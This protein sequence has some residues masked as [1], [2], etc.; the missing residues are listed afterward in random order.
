MSDCCHTVA[1]TVTRA[2]G[3]SADRAR[4]EVR[5]VMIDTRPTRPAL[6]PK[7]ATGWRSISLLCWLLAREQ[8][9]HAAILPSVADTEPIAGG[10]AAFKGRVRYSGVGRR[11]FQLARQPVRELARLTEAAHG[12]LRA[13]RCPD[14]EAL[15]AKRP[16]LN[17]AACSRQLQERRCRVRLPGCGYA[18]AHRPHATQRVT[19]YAYL[20]CARYSPG[21]CR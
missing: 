18:V 5:A 9:A 13:V 3:E 16:H 6:D 1:T 21:R 2:T 20:P 10:D 7:P 12:H 4:R 19:K 17:G 15:I 14:R 11:L 8:V